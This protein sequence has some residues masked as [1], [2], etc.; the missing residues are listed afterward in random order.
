MLDTRGLKASTESIHTIAD[1]FV[2]SAEDRRELYLFAE[3]QRRRRPGRIEAWHIDPSFKLT[4][5]GEIDFAAGHLSYPSVFKCDDDVFII[6]ETSSPKWHAGEGEVALYRFTS[7]PTRVEKLAIL[8]VG[9]YV[10]SSVFLWDGKWYLFTTLKNDGLLFVSDRLEG[11]YQPHPNSPFSSQNSNS[12][13]AG[14]ILPPTA[15]RR[16][17]LRPAQNCTA[18][19]GGDLSLMKIIQLDP[20]NYREEPWAENVV[21][22]N[23][24][25]AA[26]GAHHLS[27]CVWRD[28]TVT[29]LDG[30]QNDF[31]VNRLLGVFAR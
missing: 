19:Y 18:S 21:A 26:T 22:G 10:D 6:P 17:A 3:V 25:W 8:L 23:F 12:R 7:F 14:A 29:A 5:L 4:A 31:L 28:R 9:P 24:P 27:Q 30:R 16:F 13:S 2:F 11:P 1:P 20:E 15:K